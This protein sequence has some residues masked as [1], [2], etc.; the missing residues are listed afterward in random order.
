MSS[1]LQSLIVHYLTWL[2]TAPEPHALEIRGHTRFQRLQV[3]YPGV[4]LTVT[5]QSSFLNHARIGS[6]GLAKRL[7]QR[8]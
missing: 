2:R 3:A 1:L 4:H 7:G 5:G 8:L 6:W